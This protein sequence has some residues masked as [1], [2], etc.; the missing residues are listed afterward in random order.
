MCPDRKKKLKKR[1]EKDAKH[2]A[3]KL[4]IV[5]RLLRFLGLETVFNRSHSWPIDIFVNKLGPGIEVIA[6]EDSQADPEIKDAVREITPLIKRPVKFV[7]PHREFE[8]AFEDLYRGYFCIIDGVNFFCKNF[9]QYDPPDLRPYRRLWEEAKGIIDSID[10]EWMIGVFGKVTCPI[11]DVLERNFRLDGTMIDARIGPNKELEKLQIVLRLIKAQQK[12]VH[13]QGSH[14]TT[15]QCHRTYAPDGLKPISWNCERL[16]IEGPKGDLPVLIEKH[17]IARLHERLPLRGHESFLHI[18]MADSLDEP[19]FIAQEPQKYLVEARMGKDKV[20]YFVAQVFPHMILIKTFLFLTM[21]GTPEA[22]RLR[23]KLG[24]CRTDVEHY[25]LDQFF[26]LVGSDIVKDPLL[27]KV[28]SECGCGHLISLIEPTDRL[29]WVERFG[30]R[31]KNKF[32]IKE[33]RQGFMVGQKLLRWSD[34]GQATPSG[35]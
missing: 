7:Y 33:A 3:R 22:E 9:Q 24:M 34:Q 35:N 1:Q 6:G 17:A 26:T 21:Q 32:D 13:Y 10:H 31:L 30:Q 29:E 23:D 11:I 16:G 14:S 2:K 8:L 19:V 27:V 5:D 18:Q 12:D 25:K 20:G 28:L 15:Y 4:N